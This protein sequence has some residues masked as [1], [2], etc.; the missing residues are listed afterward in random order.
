MYKVFFIALFLMLSVVPE[1]QSIPRDTYP[2]PTPAPSSVNSPATSNTGTFS[3]YWSMSAESEL[4][5]VTTPKSQSSAFAVTSETGAC[6]GSCPTVYYFVLEQSKDNGS[7]VPIYEGTARVKQ[8]TLTT[9]RYRFRVK[10]KETQA[11][12]APNP[13]YTYSNYT[14]VEDPTPKS[15]ENPIDFSSKVKSEVISIGKPTQKDL[16]GTTKVN[17]RVDE[18]GGATFNVPLALSPGIAGVTPQ[19]SIDYNSNNFRAG[20]IGKGWNLSGVSAITRCPK[21]PIHDDSFDM[22][23]DFDED[24]RFCLNGQKLILMSGVYGGNNAT[25][26]TLKDSFSTITSY[27]GSVSGVAYFIVKTKSGETHTYGM[28]TANN[29][30]KNNSSVIKAWYINS[31]K[32][33][34][35]NGIYFNYKTESNDE[36]FLLDYIN[37]GSSI[38]TEIGKVQINYEDK[39]KTTFGYQNTYRYSSTKRIDSITS[40]YQGSSVYR[41]YDLDYQQSNFSGVDRLISVTECASLNSNCLPSAKFNWNDENKAYRSYSNYSI[42]QSDDESRNATR[43]FDINGDGYSDMV[44]PKMELGM[45]IT[46]QNILGK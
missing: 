2:A 1:G 34:Y 35:D 24:D 33:G 17:F 22:S 16:I 23:V 37:Y 41:H 32:D 45:L 11:S 30:P 38:E 8:V 10:A 28:G 25:Y 4:L 3:V 26:K 27:S 6:T 21:T 39:T 44:Y 13:V 14:V 7:Y 31:I 15:P 29:Y 5:S 18:S 40:Y 9:G 36:E 42:A 20:S 19:L 43:I 46:V 12:F